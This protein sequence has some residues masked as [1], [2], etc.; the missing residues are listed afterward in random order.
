MVKHNGMFDSE[1]DMHVNEHCAVGRGGGFWW[2]KCG[3]AGTRPHFGIMK[4][5]KRVTSVGSRN[6]KT[7]RAW[8]LDHVSLTELSLTF[9]ILSRFDLS[10]KGLALDIVQL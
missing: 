9:V 8:N 3:P 7:R 4:L 10:L 6:L 2:N 1:N 5:A